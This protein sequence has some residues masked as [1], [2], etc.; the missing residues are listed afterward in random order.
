MLKIY[1]KSSVMIASMIFLISFAAIGTAAFAVEPAHKASDLP[2]QIRLEL[3]KVPNFGVFDNIAFNL[4]D[5]D[6]VVLTGQVISPVVKSGAEIALLRIPG[7][8]K[9]VNNIEVLPLSRMDD[10]IRL[11]TYYA[12]YSNN[13]F[14]KY[15]TMAQAPIRIIVDNGHVTLE[16]V[17]ANKIDKSMA[18]LSANTVPGVFSVTDNLRIG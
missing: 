15:A 16:G 6:T 18:V 9:V 4:E 13:G 2:E 12:V 10:E 17:V 3:I 7:I 14:E 5:S 8:K 1:K 11:K